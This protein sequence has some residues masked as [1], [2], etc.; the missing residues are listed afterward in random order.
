MW[1]K[2]ELDFSNVGQTCTNHIDSFQKQN[3]RFHR[4]NFK[5]HDLSRLTC[6]H[7]FNPNSLKIEFQ[8]GIWWCCIKFAA[9]IEKSYN[10]NNYLLFVRSI[11]RNEDPWPVNIGDMTWPP[12][13]VSVRSGHLES[14]ASCSHFQLLTSQIVINCI[15]TVPFDLI[16]SAINKVSHTSTHIYVKTNRQKI[17]TWSVKEVNHRGIFWGQKNDQH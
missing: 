7:G 6:D 5:K 16:S 3:G 13:L 1:E 2:R 8:I 17:Q 15:L 11:A 9:L 4:L 12:T 14:H 10:K